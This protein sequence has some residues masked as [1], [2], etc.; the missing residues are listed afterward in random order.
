MNIIEIYFLGV[1]IAFVLEL[2]VALRIKEISSAT[3][4]FPIIFHWMWILAFMFWVYDM[5]GLQYEDLRKPSL[6]IWRMRR[7][8]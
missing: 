8:K 6:C 1:L 4:L 3:F 7:R 5:L 2:F